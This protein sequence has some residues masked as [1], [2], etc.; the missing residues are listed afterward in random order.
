M[1]TKYW[2]EKLSLQ[3]HPEGG[4]YRETYRSSLEITP[5][6]FPG[7]RASST[8]IY[9]LL[10]GGDFSALHR[11]RSDEMWHFYAGSTLLLRAISHEGS[12]TEIKLGNNP[13]AGEHF[14]AVVKAGDWFGACLQDAH[15]FAL[16][17]CTVAPGFDFTDFELGERAGLVK[18]YPQHRTLIKTLT[19]T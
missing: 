9:F 12:A 7:N 16:V 13:E 3:P 5:K 4:F 10:E 6:G 14:Q 2:I 15:S 1:N 18:A 17:A 19:R 11:L 8:A